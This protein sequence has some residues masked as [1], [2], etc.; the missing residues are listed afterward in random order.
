MLLLKFLLR[1][2]LNT[3]KHIEYVWITY[4]LNQIDKLILQTSSSNE[5]PWMMKFVWNVIV[6]V[7][8]NKISTV[9]H[10][11]IIDWTNVVLPSNL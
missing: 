3:N 7:K 6:G 5:F 2:L 8:I 9:V 11:F 4:I 1:H 10:K